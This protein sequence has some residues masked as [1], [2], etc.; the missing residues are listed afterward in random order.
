MNQR[1]VKSATWEDSSTPLGMT[2]RG[3]SRST[4]R[5]IFVTEPA[6][7]R[8]WSGDESSPLHCSVYRG[9]PFNRTGC[10]RYVADGRL[11]PLHF[12][13]RVVPF[14]HTGC[15]CHVAGGRLPPLRHHPLD[16]RLIDTAQ[17]SKRG[18]AMGHRRYICT[19]YW[20]V[21]FTHTGYSCHV[22]GGY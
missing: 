5:V 1:K 12:A 21:A 14:T 18:M 11:P 3:W 16:Y 4:K 9:I 7:R 17:A 22:A 8:G 10:I 2:Y 6:P 15:I 20:V 19:V 13:Y